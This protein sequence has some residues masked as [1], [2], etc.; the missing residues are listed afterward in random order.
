MLEIILKNFYNIINR[1]NEEN[2]NNIFNEKIIM[3]DIDLNSSLDNKNILGLKQKLDLIYEKIKRSPSY[4]GKDANYKLIAILFLLSLGSVSSVDKNIA[5]ISN[6]MNLFTLYNKIYVNDIHISFILFMNAIIFINLCIYS[7]KKKGHYKDI[8]YDNKNIYNFYYQEFKRKIITEKINEQ[9]ENNQRYISLFLF[10]ND[11]ITFNGD[12]FFELLMFQNYLKIFSIYH[13]S[14]NQIKLTINLTIDTIVETLKTFS[15]TV[16]LINNNTNNIKNNFYIQDYIINKI[17]I[18]LSNLLLFSKN[19]INKCFSSFNF[20]ELLIKVTN[21]QRKSQIEAIN[22]KYYELIQKTKKLYF[23]NPITAINQTNIKTTNDA[24]ME[25]DN[26][27]QDNS[28]DTLIEEFKAIQYLLMYYKKTKEVKK[29][30]QFYCFKFR[31]FKCSVFR[32]NQKDIQIFF[33][34]SS[35]KEKIFP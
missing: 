30:L 32:E 35:V 13:L 15:D 10:D 17:N 1:N 29:Y 19:N 14:K 20:N 9:N 3:N 11:V 5:Q 8:I 4:N 31:F 28:L 24:Q 33:D 25:T 21:F 22:N 23:Q 7:N 2:I 34:Y 6:L 16:I 18:K 12:Y 27:I 26:K